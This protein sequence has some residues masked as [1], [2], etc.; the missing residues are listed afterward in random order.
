VELIT[1]HIGADFDALASSLIARKLYP[2]AELFF[3]GSREES[4]RRMLE[5]GFIE[6]DELRQ[7]QIDPDRLSRVVLCDI[8]QPDR[9]GAVARWLRE[10]PEI[11]LVIYDHH[12]HAEDDLQAAAG[13][14]DPAV[15]STSTLLVEELAERG[16]GLSS[17]EASLMLMGIYEDTGSLSYATTGPRDLAAAAWLLERGGDLAAVRRFALRRLDARRL[18]VLHRMTDE[19]KIYHL[20]GHRVGIV[21]LEL[22][23]FIDELAPLVGRCLELFELPLLFGVFGEGERV[24]VIARGHVAGMD[25]GRFLTERAGGGG[26]ATAAAASLKGRTVLEVREQL[27]EGLAADL[28]PLA[29]AGDLMLPD[30]QVLPAAESVMAAKKRLNR[31]RLNAAPV[32]EERGSRRV[33]G[34]VTRQ[35]LDSA[36]QH[37]LGERSVETIMERDL[38]WVAP[39]APAEEIAER[40]MGRHPRLV[41]VGDPATAEPLGVATRMQVLRH[42]Y[43][44]LEETADPLGRRARERRA[45]RAD[46]GRL[47]REGLAE[48]VARRLAVVSASA[49]EH[50]IRAYL[51]G[52][53]V[54]D[55]LL[56]RDNRDVDLVVEGDGPHFAH[57][58]SDRLGGRVREHRPFMTAVLVDS[59]GFHIDVASARSEFYRAPAALPEVRN[60][61]IRQDLYRRDFTINTLAIRLGPE[62]TPEMIDFFGG[63]RDLEERILRVLHSLSFIDDPTRVLRGV[64]L[65]C[66]LGFV[67][68]AETLRLVELALAEGVFN[69]LSGPRLRDE[70]M[71]LLDDPGT[72]LRGLERLAELGLL[73][74]L[75]PDLVWGQAA[76]R[77]ISATAAAVDWY[78]LAGME[79]PPVQVGQLFLAALA[80]ELEAGE[81]RRLGER[82]ALGGADL[83]ALVDS[84]SRV[85]SA[86]SDLSSPALEPH[87]ADAILSPLSGEEILLVM[88]LG[89]DRQR[90]WVRRQLTEFRVLELA[91]RGA[92]LVDRGVPAG[93][94][95]G[96]ALA[97]TR[98]ARIDGR[99]DSSGELGYALE[100]VSDESRGGG[101]AE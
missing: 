64:R 31:Q 1:T 7:R 46:V 80:W 95:V 10:R 17:R 25:L 45:R 35:I 41:L 52:G 75:H 43:G 6:L 36:L 47:L 2:E 53:M 9:I 59:D 82:L 16:L 44:R 76:R 38:E 87:G 51:V 19:L 18:D 72:A 4:V 91:I 93:P 99:I 21:A 57:L 27:L 28:P 8:R 70:L 78:L 37:G 24:T 66:R 54:R 15:G 89:D 40:M 20:R 69:R 23:A 50:G 60:S 84:R 101:E 55:L 32:V 13:R 81:R 42:L 62:E 98:A 30:F 67:L 26:H 96:R 88:A 56:G 97:A 11:E 90:D 86:L 58:L 34:V 22:G 85:E 65:E 5:S 71:Q 77:R 92:D 33:V 48:P 63:R 68:S 29:C 100:V 39:E 49:R 12:P 14:I 73:G 61:P 94:I 79:D 83:N 3:P 74:V